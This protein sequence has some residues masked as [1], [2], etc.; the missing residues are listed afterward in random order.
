MDNNKSMLVVNPV[1][2]N[3]MKAIYNILVLNKLDII[4]LG[5]RTIV[6]NLCNKVNLNINLLQIIQCNNESEI[7]YRLKKIKGIN[8]IQG[9]IYDEINQEKIFNIFQYHSICKMI[10][11][12]VF[13]KS[14]FLIR[15]TTKYNLINN[16]KESMKLINSFQFKLLNIGIVYSNK[17]K[18]LL[19]RKILKQHLNI[20]NID[21]ID[22]RKIKNNN[23]NIIIFDDKIS[24]QEYIDKIN[25]MVLPRIIDI[26]IYNNIFLF[27]ANKQQFKNI[28]FQFMFIQK[29]KPLNYQIYTQTF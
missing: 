19:K 1:S 28:F 27:N 21:I 9:I 12:G 11:F 23:Y 24:E 3:I 22:I 10:D 17:D 6:Y 15:N 18:A 8:N 26:N 20:R 14:V 29:L 5:N 16:I 2:V 13:K 25:N 4:I 7:L